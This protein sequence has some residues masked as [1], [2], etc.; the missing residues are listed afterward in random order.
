[1]EELKAKFKGVKNTKSKNVENILKHIKDVDKNLL[2]AFLFFLGKAK[3]IEGVELQF[4]MDGISGHCYDSQGRDR[5]AFY[6][7]IRTTHNDLVVYQLISV[8]DPK[9]IF[10]NVEPN[11]ARAKY[12]Y[13]S[14]NESE[15]N[16]YVLNIFRRC[17]EKINRD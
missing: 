11:K 3:E 16:E 7:A 10:N 8:F 4:R 14:G 13:I 6:F 2:D 17:V 1:M 12:G 9:E 15:E 5:E